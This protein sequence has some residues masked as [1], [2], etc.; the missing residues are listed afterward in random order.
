MTQ[1]K[2]T[3]MKAEIS[4]KLAALGFAL[5]M[6]VAIIGGVA[7]LFNAQLHQALQTIAL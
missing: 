2:E 5:L 3:I 1:T 7:L 6:N 4:T